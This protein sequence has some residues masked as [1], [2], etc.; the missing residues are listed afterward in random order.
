[1]AH[2]ASNDDG[3]NIQSGVNTPALPFT[4]LLSH[5]ASAAATVGVSLFVA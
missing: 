5:N 3:G 1:L 2:V 4:T